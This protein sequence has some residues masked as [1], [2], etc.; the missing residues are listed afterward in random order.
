MGEQA[1]EDRQMQ[2]QILP[3]PLMEIEKEI[4][5]RID[6]LPREWYQ[7]KNT[8]IP[9]A[10]IPYPEVRRIIHESFRKGRN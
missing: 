5:E 2:V 8:H 6:K 4:V 9:I 1:V 10:V 7:F 3:P